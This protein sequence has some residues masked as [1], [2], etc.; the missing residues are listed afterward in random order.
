M[1][2]LPRCLF[3]GHTIVRAEYGPPVA[4]RRYNSGKRESDHR[5]GS[6]IHTDTQEASPTSGIDFNFLREQTHLLVQHV[7]QMRH[8][9]LWVRVEYK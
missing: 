5:N 2:W 7:G 8:S 6:T 4:I 1:K 3:G 9:L